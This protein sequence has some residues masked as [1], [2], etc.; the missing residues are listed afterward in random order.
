MEA[1]P[2]WPI[3]VTDRLFQNLSCA[4]IDREVQHNQSKEVFICHCIQIVIILHKHHEYY[5][6]SNQLHLSNFIVNTKFIK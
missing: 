5:E 2:T 4:I 6:H 1:Q 3:D